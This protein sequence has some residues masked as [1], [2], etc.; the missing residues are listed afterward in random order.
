MHFVSQ[1]I[2][3]VSHLPLL[4]I[5]DPTA[6]RIVGAGFKT[7]GLLGTKFT[8][9]KDFYK[10]RLSEKFGLAVVVPDQEG[11]QAIHDIIYSELCRGIIREESRE[12]YARIIA[13]M[14]T[15]GAECLILGCTGIGRLVEEA[16][17][18]YGLRIY[19]T[20][21]LNAGAAADWAMHNAS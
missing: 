9:E 1:D 19:D 8:M 2:E 10:S 3:S 21:R 6:E 18:R 5:V 7:V 15:A 17:G 16:A 11:R 20:T 14:K 12:V 13:E 4:H